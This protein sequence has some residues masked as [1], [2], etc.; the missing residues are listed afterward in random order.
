MAKLVLQLERL[1]CP[2]CIKKIENAL[3]RTEGIDSAKVLFMTSKA[4]VEFDESI[5]DENKIEKTIEKLGYK[6]LSVNNREWRYG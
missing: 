4:R 6:V 5:I 3:K 2:S 1:T